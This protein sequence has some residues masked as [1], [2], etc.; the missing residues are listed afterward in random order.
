MYLKLS[1]GNIFHDQ[2]KAVDSLQL[3]N[4]VT[5]LI[6]NKNVR[7]IDLDQYSDL[8]LEELKRELVGFEQEKK[9]GNSS[10]KVSIYEITSGNKPYVKLV[11]LARSNDLIQYQNRH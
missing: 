11:L 8:S 6:G 1:I 3:V 2:G 7:Y 4:A 5:N 9:L 10:I